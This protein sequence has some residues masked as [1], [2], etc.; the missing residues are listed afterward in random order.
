MRMKLVHIDQS[1]MRA[2]RREP[3]VVLP[4]L[5]ASPAPA[6][7]IGGWLR[8]T[9]LRRAV[10]SY[11]RRQAAMLRQTHAAMSLAGPAAL[12]AMPPLEAVLDLQTDWRGLHYL[13][14]GTPKSGLAPLNLLLAGGEDLGADLGLGP[15]RLIEESAVREF[16]GALHQNSFETLFARTD[17]RHRSACGAGSIENLGPQFERLKA[18]VADAV[19]L[20]RGA[21]IWLC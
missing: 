8:R 12:A 13:L 11:V 15:I 7:G 14:T 18:F 5:A 2:L 19:A 21:L 6:A 3:G 1:Q 9:R 4:F 10:A 16:S 17:P 20:R